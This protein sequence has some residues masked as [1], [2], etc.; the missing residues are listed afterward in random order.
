MHPR[1]QFLTAQLTFQPTVRVVDWLA[2]LESRSATIRLG[3]PSSHAGEV[4]HAGIVDHEG[5]IDHEGDTVMAED[6]S[7]VV[8][9]ASGQGGVDHAV[10]LSHK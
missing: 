1:H 2:G 4:G 8:G 3:G 7:T 10:S 6:G 5:D 9:E